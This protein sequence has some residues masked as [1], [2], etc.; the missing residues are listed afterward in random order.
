[1]VGGIIMVGVHAEEI[2]HRDKKP[3]NDS[4]VTLL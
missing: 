3:E 2:T 4:G 1:M